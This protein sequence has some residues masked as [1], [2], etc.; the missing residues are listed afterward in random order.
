[1]PFAYNFSLPLLTPFG[2]QSTGGSKSS[3]N[4][5]NKPQEVAPTP[6]PKANDTPTT[7]EENPKVPVGNTVG[8]D[9]PVALGRAD[10]G[11]AEVD[12]VGPPLKSTNPSTP[13]PPK[14]NDEKGGESLDKCE[15]SGGGTCGNGKGG[16]IL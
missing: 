3:S 6:T 12:E 8:E 4:A 1:M 13:V 16:K 5:N 7:P 9:D 15:K 10:N 11:S 2:S 14:I